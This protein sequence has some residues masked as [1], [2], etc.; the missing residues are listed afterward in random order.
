MEPLPFLPASQPT[1]FT[2][3]FVFPQSLLGPPSLEPPPSSQHHLHDF[4]DL[5]LP[6]N[7][8]TLLADSQSP[9]QLDP[10][11]LRPFFPTNLRPPLRPG[12]TMSRAHRKEHPI[13]LAQHKQQHLVLR[14]H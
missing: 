7:T 10:E 3:A 9:E 2:P 12:E 11:R 5:R 6:Q 14:R 4:L 1:T 13:Q 8:L